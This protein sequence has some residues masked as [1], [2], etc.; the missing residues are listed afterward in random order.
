MDPRVSETGYWDHW[1]LRSSSLNQVTPPLEVSGCLDTSLDQ[2][3]DLLY[4]LEP[5]REFD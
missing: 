4:P 5:F 3:D 1:Y 2:E